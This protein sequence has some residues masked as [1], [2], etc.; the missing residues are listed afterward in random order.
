MNYTSTEFFVDSSSRFLFTGGQT[1]RQ[2]DRQTDRRNLS[3]WP[4]NV[5]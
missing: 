1:Y 4:P 3:P 5:E 2:T